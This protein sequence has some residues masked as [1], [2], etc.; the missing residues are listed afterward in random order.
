MRERELEEVCEKNSAIPGFI[1]MFPACPALVPVFKRLLQMKLHC[2]DQLTVAAF[3]HHLIAAKI[4]GGEE[5][6][7]GGYLI[8]LKTV[9]LPDAQD[10]RFD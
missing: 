7:T 10:A 2:V 8:K 9:I 1:L 5:F 3:H 6:E 4:R